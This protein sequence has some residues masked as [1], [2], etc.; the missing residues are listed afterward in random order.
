MVGVSIIIMLFVGKFTKGID[1]AWGV[2]FMY[3]IDFT[4]YK[5]IYKDNTEYANIT[6]TAK[7][8][9][10]QNIRRRVNGLG[11]GDAE[12]KLQKAGGDDYL[13]VRIGGLDDLD[14]A[15][16]IIWKTVELEFA[17]PNA[18]SWSN[19]VEER[20]QFAAELLTEIKKN[21]STMKEIGDQGSSDVYYFE[22]TWASKTQLPTALLAS[23]EDLR[24]LWS[25]QVLN[26]LIQ[27]MFQ[28]A[29]PSVS[30]S[31]DVNGFFIIKSLGKVEGQW[32]KISDQE[33]MGKALWKGYG[34]GDDFVTSKPLPKWKVI[35][36]D[37][38]YNDA[39]KSVVLDLGQP[40]SGTIAYE[41]DVYVSW[42]WSVTGLNTATFET[43]LEWLGLSKVVDKKRASVAQL[44]LLDGLNLEKQTIKTI[45][46]GGQDIVIKTYSVKKESDSLY[47]T[48]TLKNLPSEEVATSFIQ[49]ILSNDVY[50]L[51]VVF[52]RDTNSW[53]PARDPQN[54]V[55]N[56]AYF[57]LATVTRDQVGRPAVQIDLDDTGKD[58]F[59][60]ITEGN[61]QKQMAIFVGGVLVT[62]PTI[63]D[64]ICGGTAIINGEYDMATAKTLADSLNEWALPA[65]LIQVNESK[66]SATLGENA[67]KWAL[68]A[69]L[70]SFVLITFLMAWR[71]G[72]R[73]AIISIVALVTFIIVL[74]AILKL[75]NYALSLSGMAA[76]I[77]NIGM[78]I[79][80]AVLIYERLREEL[81]SGKRTSDAIYTAYDRARDA[82]WAGQMS[83][84][85][86]WALLVLLGSDLFQW[87]GLVMILNIVILLAVS[88]PLIK[89]LLI[90]FDK[91]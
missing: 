45:S 17:L 13:V 87:F 26:N 32:G 47:R 24:N 68:W 21:P 7:N 84:L 82:I 53:L 34:V 33:L 19:Q 8:I 39:D 3:K 12:V 57:K 27:W 64:K 35:S 23:T 77:L 28:Q 22:I 58:I 30:G 75:M 67:W 56:G 1:V 72:L 36:Q 60:K 37:I 16:A 43:N 46:T 65:K 83:T 80:A 90:K 81:A 74:V 76:I 79:D 25:G 20:K 71:Y 6:Q 2:E 91:E 63:Q 89:R 42:T 49:D 52:V 50:N 31:T 9:I 69:T 61:I 40:F 62:A 88:V 66:V 29:D 54:R 73:K 44:P 51:E 15:R 5:E 78:G 18:L 70:L 48:I 85:A 4:K 38:Y 86:I 41:V 11:V 55:L 14:K 59:C 10:E